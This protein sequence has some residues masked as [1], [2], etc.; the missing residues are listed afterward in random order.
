MEQRILANAIIK[1][2]MLWDYIDD[3]FGIWN[4]G[5]EA[6]IIL[7]EEINHTHPTIRLMVGW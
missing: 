6:L 3:V 2:F 1:P 5:E 7:V 4:H